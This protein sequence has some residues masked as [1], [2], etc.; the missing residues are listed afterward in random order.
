L[1]VI[2]KN[3]Y[4]RLCNVKTGVISGGGISSSQM[5]VDIPF[6]MQMADQGSV[7]SVV[8]ALVLH[9]ALALAG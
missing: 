3:V 1:V 8:N 5:K 6:S 7:E 9:A 4:S 2:A